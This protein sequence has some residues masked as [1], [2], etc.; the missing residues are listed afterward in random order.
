M[1]ESIYHIAEQIVEIH[2]RA[3]SRRIK[4]DEIYL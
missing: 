1:D 3:Y 4:I 2:Q